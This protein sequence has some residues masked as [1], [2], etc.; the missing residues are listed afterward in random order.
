MLPASVADRVKASFPLTQELS[1]L[2]EVQRQVGELMSDG[3][4]AVEFFDRTL[5]T[6]SVS[7]EPE[8]LTRTGRDALEQTLDLAAWL[9]LYRPTIKLS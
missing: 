7:G 2:R 4:R 1:Y 8:A 5:L 6:E 9:D 3:D